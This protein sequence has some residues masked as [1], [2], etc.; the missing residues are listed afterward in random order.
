MEIGANRYI[1]AN[2]WV[3]THYLWILEWETQALN[4]PMSFIELN[5]F[6]VILKLKWSPMFVIVK[7]HLWKLFC[8]F[9]EYLIVCTLV[10]ICNILVL[11]K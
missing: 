9:P 1:P 6:M 10:K 2:T 7:F 11:I 4:T 8:Q 5:R 3:N